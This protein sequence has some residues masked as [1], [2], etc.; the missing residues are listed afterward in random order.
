MPPLAGSHSLGAAWVV[1][2]VFSHPLQ[3]QLPGWWAEGMRGVVA[4]PG[5]RSTA[6][7]VRS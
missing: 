2:Q 1:V 5:T 6:E 3:Q 7:L 4:S